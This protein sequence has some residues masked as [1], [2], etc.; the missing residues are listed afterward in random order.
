MTQ[1]KQFLLSCEVRNPLKSTSVDTR[2]A[3]VDSG[4]RRGGAGD[5]EARPA[6]GGDGDGPRQHQGEVP[7]PGTAETRTGTRRLER[8]VPSVRTG[9]LD[10][11]TYF[12]A[13]RLK[14][15]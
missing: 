11:F 2:C 15:L 12:A 5:G 3:A 6:E 8:Q 14:R 13:Y 4:T 1:I 7:Q 9:I 10:F